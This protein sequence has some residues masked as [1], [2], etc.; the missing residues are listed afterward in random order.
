MAHYFQ[1]VLV[2]LN[3]DIPSTLVNEFALQSDAS[4]FLLRQRQDELYRANMLFRHLRALPAGP[5]IKLH[6]VVCLDNEET[7]QPGLAAH[8]GDVRQP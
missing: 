3:P 6:P 5:I 1:F 2:Q 7:A 4:Y 8:Q